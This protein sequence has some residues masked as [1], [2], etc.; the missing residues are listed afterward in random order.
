MTY[1]IKNISNNYVWVLKNQLAPGDTLNLDKVFE[2]IC[3]P[4]ASSR[5][6][7]EP[8]VPKFSEFKENEFDEFMDWV[9][10][11]IVTERGV[12]DIVE[13]VMEEATPEPTKKERR[14]FKKAKKPVGDIKVR[15]DVEALTEKRQTHKQVGKKLPSQ[16]ELSPKQIAWLPFDKT[17]KAIIGEM[18]DLKRLK[19]AF[20]LVRNLPAREQTRK[21][22]EDRIAELQ[23]LGR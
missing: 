17:S 15:G 19:S 16:K 12:L 3:K 9:K 5:A 7:A 8:D 4:K 10:E 14:A 18:D 22:I 6:E 2:G 23:G 21:L 11:E 1:F 20:R 13:D